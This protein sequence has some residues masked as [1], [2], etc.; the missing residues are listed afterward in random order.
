MISRAAS[1]LLE[2]AQYLIEVAVLDIGG[3]YLN[4]LMPKDNPVHMRI[5]PALADIIVRQVLRFKNDFHQVMV[6]QHPVK[7]YIPIAIPKMQE[8]V[9]PINTRLDDILTI[10][11][12]GEIQGHAPNYLFPPTNNVRTLQQRP[13]TI[14]AMD[15]SR[16]FEATEILVMLIKIFGMKMQISDLLFIPSLIGNASRAQSKIIPCL[17]L[18]RLT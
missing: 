1:Y 8:E 6:T 11:N 18:P 10:Y 16:L 5:E 17:T 2:Y 13:M 9:L 12:S 4:A 7:V 3:A 14:G 15:L